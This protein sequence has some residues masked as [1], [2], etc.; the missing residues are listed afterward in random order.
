MEETQGTSTCTAKRWVFLRKVAKLILP[1]IHLNFFVLTNRYVINA[2]R[3]AVQLSRDTL[4]GKYC[5]MDWY[6]ELRE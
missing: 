2:A 6:K 1:K 4:F 5:N 3:V